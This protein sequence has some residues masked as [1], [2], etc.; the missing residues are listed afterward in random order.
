VNASPS[1]D[2][3]AVIRDVRLAVT[4]ALGPPLD[5]VVLVHPR[6]VPKTSSGKV[7]RGLCRSML[8]ARELNV[9]AEWSLPG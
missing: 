7:Q 4:R 8:L 1:L 5:V 3:D 2:S 6:S 9:V